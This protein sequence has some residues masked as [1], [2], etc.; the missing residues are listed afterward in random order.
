M[1]RDPFAGLLLRITEFTPKIELNTRWSFKNV[2]SP[3]KMVINGFELGAPTSMLMVGVIRMDV[4]V[5]ITTEVLLVVL[6]IS[7]SSPLLVSFKVW[8]S[9]ESN[10][11]FSRGKDCD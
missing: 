9:A 8:V 7:L 3:K 5:F 6:L 1:V 10:I 2:I 4:E 11:R